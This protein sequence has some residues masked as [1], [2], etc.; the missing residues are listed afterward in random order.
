VKI[1]L[2]GDATYQE[3][4]DLSKVIRVVHLDGGNACQ[5]SPEASRGTA[6]ISQPDAA[7]RSLE[8]FDSLKLREG[9]MHHTYGNSSLTYR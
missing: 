5:A 9:S 6:M 2:S 3:L 8:V 1:H 7:G 4:G